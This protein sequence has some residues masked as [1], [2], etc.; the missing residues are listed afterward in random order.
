[1]VTHT[2]FMFWWLRHGSMD[3]KPGHDTCVLEKNLYN[4]FF[5]SFFLTDFLLFIKHVESFSV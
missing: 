3:L 5:M 4:N 2:K 1:M